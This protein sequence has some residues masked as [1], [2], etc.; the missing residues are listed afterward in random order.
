MMLGIDPETQ[1]DRMANDATAAERTRYIRLG[2][3][4]ISL[5]Y[6]HPFMVADP[7]IQLDYQ[8]RGAGNVRLRPRPAA[9]VTSRVISKYAG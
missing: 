7:I 8:T 4:V 3:A 9:V 2:T 5:P 1:R 6:R